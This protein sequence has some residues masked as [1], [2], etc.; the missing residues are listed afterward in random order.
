M[1]ISVSNADNLGRPK[2]K[3]SES[4]C[5]SVLHWTVPFSSVHGHLPKTDNCHRILSQAWCHIINIQDMIP[6]IRSD[7]TFM[8]RL[9]WNC[10]YIPEQNIQRSALQLWWQKCY[11]REA[12]RKGVHVF[13]PSTFRIQRHGADEEELRVCAWQVLL[14]VGQRQSEELPQ[15]LLPIQALSSGGLLRH[16]GQVLWLWGWPALRHHQ[17]Q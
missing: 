16:R 5:V 3:S 9:H 2:T 4:R 12:L 15:T 1:L 10:F 11:N 7:T 8:A 17:V 6:S 13:S 14:P